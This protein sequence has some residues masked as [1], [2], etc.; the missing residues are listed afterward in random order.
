MTIALFLG[1][2][3]VSIAL[4]FLSRNRRI[5]VEKIAVISAVIEFIIGAFLIYRVVQA[6]SY[7]TGSFTV[8]SF[9]GL[10][11]LITLILGLAI[12]F[13]SVG[14]LRGEMAKKMITEQR[15]W[16]CHI[17]LQTFLLSMMI[18]VTTSYPMIMWIAIEGTTLS[19]AFLI[20]FFHRPRDIE[21]SWKYL[22]I[23]TL[24]LLMAL[25][26][27][28]LFSPLA[29]GHESAT[30]ESLSEYMA[31]ANP[32][33]IKYAFIFI[34]VG[35]GTKMG[36]VPMH[37]WKPDAYNKGPIPFVALLSTAL[38]NVALFALLRFKVLS[39][40]NLGPEF[41]QTLML[42]FGT[43]SLVTGSFILYT[44]T[45]FKRLFAYSSVENAGLMVLSFAFGGLGIFAGLLHMVFHSLIKSL[46]FMLAG[47][48]S[49][50]YSSSQI[51]EVRGMLKVLPVTGI[52]FIAAIL[53]I[54]GIPP[55][56]IFFS[57]FY[58][59]LAGM[60]T[61]PVITLVAFLAVTIAF[62]GLLRITFS[63]VY[64]EPPETIQKGESSAWTVAPPVIL[65]ILILVLSLYMPPFV[66]TLIDRSQVILQ[67]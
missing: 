17:L 56:G 64:G 60:E 41:A 42:F 6:G 1:T 26:G 39:S 34:L 19:S 21:A 63:M 25:L 43:I 61:H 62:I 36:L 11:I 66:R 22:I 45:N 5:A 51:T 31:H 47:N 37:T 12:T 24:G 15:L 59:L 8:D 10:L 49:L 53:A 65:F 28:L 50:K 67:K 30:W 46:L 4:M 9:S 54:T 16:E 7:S 20:N 23:N 14:Y 40:I 13:Y 58:M 57:K 55:S 29:A 35:Y 44:R 38:L 18:A 3:L 32:S 2:Y 52:L 48:I 33:V 27:T